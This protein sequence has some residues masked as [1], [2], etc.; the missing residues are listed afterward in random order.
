MEMIALFR[1]DKRNKYTLL[2]I[3]VI[4]AVLILIGNLVYNI[5]THDARANKLPKAPIISVNTGDNPPSYNITYPFTIKPELT[6]YQLNGK[7][8]TTTSPKEALPLGEHNIK[9]RYKVNGKYSEWA[10]KDFTIANGVKQVALGEN[11]TLVLMIDG[12]VKGWGSNL[13]GQLGAVKVETNSAGAGG[14]ATSGGT[15]TG[16]AGN[17]PQVGSNTENAGTNAG[18]N[19]NA[20]NN[21]SGVGNT[22]NTTSTAG[23]INPNT[24]PTT[25]E[26]LTNV[27]QIA[28]GL[29]HCLALMADGTVK[30]WGLNNFGQLGINQNLG[31]NVANPV[32]VT[33]PG[34]SNVKQLV[35][36]PDYSMALLA[37]GTVKAWGNNCFGQLGTNINL[38]SDK[39]N[40]VPNTIP[41]LVG[42]KQISAGAAHAVALLDSGTIKAWGQNTYGQLGFDTKG[43]AVSVTTKIAG[44]TRVEQISAGAYHTVALM[45]DGTVKAWGWNNG[46]QLGNSTNSTTD[47]PNFEPQ[48]I[49]GIKGVRQVSGG[50]YHTAVLMEDG[51]LKVF[52]RNNYGQLGVS[53]NAGTTN[54]N[55]EPSVV[56][57][58]KNVKQIIT[59]YNHTV[60]LKWD[61]TINIWG[62]NNMSQL[63]NGKTEDSWAPLAV[64]GLVN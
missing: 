33:I 50:C 30:A 9:V 29:N 15:N 43:V 23:S 22:G 36:G 44:F 3:T 35:A 55:V 61:N 26:G 49:A 48:A 42:A 1:T 21:T 39:A 10:S 31:T 12:T 54:P 56:Q 52:G 38:G 45:S 6:E 4:I 57:E 40:P 60:A 8:I 14:E 7:D 62:W 28:S 47:L 2:K 34:I 27:K 11:Y 24:V 25:V 13:Y 46:G 17:T 59:G 41:D 58:L 20:G 32:P 53:N 16:N 18:G 63:G 64:N 51:T 37:D 19:T 5:F